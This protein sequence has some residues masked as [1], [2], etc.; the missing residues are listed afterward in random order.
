MIIKFASVF[1][2]PLFISEQYCG[3]FVLLYQLS[4]QNAFFY[5]EKSRLWIA[6]FMDNSRWPDFL[7]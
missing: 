4:N 1:M 2:G 3:G 7:L 6:L 5:T